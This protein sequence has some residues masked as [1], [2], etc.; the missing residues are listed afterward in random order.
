MTDPLATVLLVS[1]QGVRAPCTPEPQGAV[2]MPLTPVT[3][4][5]FRQ[6]DG[7]PSRSQTAD[8]PSQSVSYLH[9]SLQSYLDV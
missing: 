9:L 1:P 6:D 3:P 4:S 5:R 8:E 7:S 2:F